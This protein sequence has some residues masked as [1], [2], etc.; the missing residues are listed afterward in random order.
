MH[1]YE[2]SA[3]EGLVPNPCLFDIII[4]AGCG[5]LSSGTQQ[6]SLYFYKKMT[7]NIS[8][9][10]TFVQFV[11]VTN[12]VDLKCSVAQPMQNTSSASLLPYIQSKIVFGTVL[13]ILV[14]KMNFLS[15]IGNVPHNDSWIG[16]LTIYKHS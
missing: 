12:G 8:E 5:M 14:Y 7:V 15:P 2:K 11:G 9:Y 6:Y 10:C 16:L 13:P 3:M 4:T 1:I